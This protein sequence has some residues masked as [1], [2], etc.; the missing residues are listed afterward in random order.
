MGQPAGPAN[1]AGEAGPAKSAAQDFESVFISAL[2]A[3][4]FES[5]SEDAT[6][7]GG[8][9]EATWSGLLTD[10]YARAISSAGGIGVAD[11]VYRELLGMQENQP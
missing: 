8:S 9:A 1:A 6:F 4:V 2:L 3:P 10:E 7:G 11:A 5:L